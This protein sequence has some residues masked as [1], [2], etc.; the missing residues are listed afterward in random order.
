MDFSILISRTSPFPIIGMLGGIFF[1]TLVDHT[2]SKQCRSWPDAGNTTS[3]LGLHC[4]PMSHKKG[5]MLLWVN[6][7]DII[8]NV[9]IYWVVKVFM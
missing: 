2:A 7:K 9:Y 3:D 6:D 4:L 5:A 1:Q 8:L